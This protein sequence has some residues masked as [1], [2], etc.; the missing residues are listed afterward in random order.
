MNHNFFMKKALSLASKGRGKTSPNPMVGAVLVKDSKIIG[1]GYHKR[2]GS[3]HAEIEAL[4]DAAVKNPGLDLSENTVLY[5]SLEPCCHRSKTKINPPCCDRIILEKIPEVVIAS[6]DPNPA[7]SGKGIIMLKE[8]GIKVSSGILEKEEKKLNRIYRHCTLHS[9]PFVLLKMAQTLDSFTARED[10]SSKWISNSKSREIVHKM[11][12]EY[13]AVLV[14]SNTVIKDD[15]QLT[16]R[17]VKGRQPLRLILD[18]SLKI[19]MESKILNDSFSGKTHIFYNPESAP[20]ERVKNHSGK[21]YSIHPAGINSSGRISL[22]EVMNI[23]WDLGIKSILAEGGST[24]AAELIKEKLINRISLF[25]APVFFIKGIHSFSFSPSGIPTKE[26]ELSET[27]INI[28]GDNIL[29][30]GNPDYS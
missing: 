18:T 11:R 3:L 4:N 15:P 21:K 29:V 26:F 20:A 14:A 25:I 19:P 13:D 8:A 6:I 17:N 2:H 5:V 24:L 23:S 12:S 28:I 9:S 16:V 10:G 22:P 7:V 1:K 27:E 30:S